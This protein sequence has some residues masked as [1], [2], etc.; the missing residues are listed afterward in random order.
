MKTPPGLMLF[1]AMAAIGSIDH[2]ESR[3]SRGYCPQS[4]EHW[5]AR[6]E[7]RAE[8]KAARKNKKRNRR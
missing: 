5:R 3:G 4:P 8:R 7:K 6:D 2:G 1:A